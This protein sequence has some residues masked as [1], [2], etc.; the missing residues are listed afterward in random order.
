MSLGLVDM[1]KLSRGDEVL[2]NTANAMERG[3]MGS[4]GGIDIYW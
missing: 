1:L 4:K 2:F 3:Y